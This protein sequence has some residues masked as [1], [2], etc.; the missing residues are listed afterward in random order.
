[1]RCN[2][3]LTHVPIHGEYKCRDCGARFPV[4]WA[5]Q[6]S[7]LFHPF[8]ST[9]PRY[10]CSL[11]AAT[12]FPLRGL[13]ARVPALGFDPAAD[14]SV[15]TEDHP[16][17]GAILRPVWGVVWFAFAAKSVHGRW[18]GDRKYRRAPS[19][20]EKKKGDLP[21]AKFSDDCNKRHVVAKRRD[22]ADNW[23]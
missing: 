14:L 11:K 22:G 23:S 5:A 10:H 7:D 1:M 8:D 13:G 9:L 2:A 17:V 21:N 19:Q 15:L 4:P 12:V 18:A 16:K 20:A 6:N 3:Q